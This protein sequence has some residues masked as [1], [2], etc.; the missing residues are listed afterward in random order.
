MMNKLVIFDCDGV[1]I[2]TCVLSFVLTYKF[3]RSI[4][5]ACEDVGWDTISYKSKLLFYNAMAFLDALDGWVIFW[6]LWVIFWN[7]V[8]VFFITTF[9]CHFIQ[10]KI[11]QMGGSLEDDSDDSTN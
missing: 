7:L 3:Y 1:L 2:V 8:I 10:D 5:D 6:N 4:Y 11:L 9:T